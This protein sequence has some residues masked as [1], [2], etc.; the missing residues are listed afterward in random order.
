MPRPAPPL[1]VRIDTSAGLDQGP[2]RVYRE[3]PITACNFLRW[4]I[5]ARAFDGGAFFRAVRS[6][7]YR[8]QSGADRQVIQVKT[9]GGE[10]E[11][12]FGPILLERTSITGLRHVRRGAVHGALGA[13]HGDVEFLIVVKASP[14]MDF[15]GRRNRDGQG[16]AVFGQVI[17][18]S[19]LR[20]IQ[21]GRADG[22]TLTPPVT[23]RRIAILS[24]GPGV[25]ARRKTCPALRRS[26]RN[27]AML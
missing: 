13:G 22:E 5:Q 3:A 1:I 20:A 10:E 17:R 26:R 24:I 15:G 14:E 6:R 21:Q 19:W 4:R 27:A 2:D 18:A 11:D 16:F 23:I 25:G 7:P 12:L 9:R 8:R